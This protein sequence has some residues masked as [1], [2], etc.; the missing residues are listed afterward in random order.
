MGNNYYNI[1]K[2]DLMPYYLRRKH[3][4]KKFENNGKINR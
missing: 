2:S 4:K 1:L 3:K